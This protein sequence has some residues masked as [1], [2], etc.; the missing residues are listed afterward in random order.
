MG[1]L[2]Q[3]VGMSSCHHQLGVPHVATQVLFLVCAPPH[4]A[5]LL[6]ELALLNSCFVSIGDRGVVT[7]SHGNL[8]AC[9]LPLKAAA[10]A[11]I[12]S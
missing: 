11:V 1:L 7:W 5:A 9:F 10:V 12:L 6:L 4:L 8:P 3:L 2:K